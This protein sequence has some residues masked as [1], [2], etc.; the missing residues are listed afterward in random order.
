MGDPERTCDALDY[1]FVEANADCSDVQPAPGEGR[2]YSHDACDLKPL[3]T[4][5]PSVPVTPVATVASVPD[6]VDIRTAVI[7]QSGLIDLRTA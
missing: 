4:T 2:W 6:I 5:I 7:D 1:C 3:T